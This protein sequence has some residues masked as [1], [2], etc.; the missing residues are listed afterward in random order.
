M[1][2]FPSKKLFVVGV[3]GTKGKSSTLELMSAIM[4]SAGIK[5]ALLNSVRRKV[6]EVSVPNKYHNSMPGRMVIQKFL[7]DAVNTGCEYAFIEVTS[8]G[9]V[10]HRHRF[11]AWDVAAFLNLAPEH[12]ES[13]GSFEKYRDAKVSFFRYAGHSLK[14]PHW[15]FVNDRDEYKSFFENAAREVSDAKVVLWNSDE[16]L[17][18]ITREEMS[19]WVKADFNI[20]NSA[21]A[22]AF[23]RS[24]GV[25]REIIKKT[26]SEFKG[27]SGRMEFVQEKP[28]A[29]VV[30][31]AHT[32]ES[33]EAI[34]KALKPVSGARL[35]GVFGSDGGGRD[36]WKRPRFGEIAEKFCD[37]IVLTEENPYDENPQEILDHIKSGIKNSDIRKNNNTLYEIIDRKEA[38]TKAIR[39]ARPGDVV[40]MTGKGSEQWLYLPKGKKIPWSEVKVVKEVINSMAIH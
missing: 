13:H 29:V 31:Y 23:A 17:K 10:Q 36:K 38:I 18:E 7:R 1:Y 25:E 34:Y 15:F 32:P 22:W 16:L 35:I 6:G 39:I 2:G 21:C 5:T 24:Q 28:F 4:E 14:H 9:V 8:Q 26:L 19:L 33:L 40:V 11:I 3:T 30:D 37:V 12:I 20:E 27:V